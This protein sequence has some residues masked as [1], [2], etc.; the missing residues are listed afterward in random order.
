MN[1]NQQK[2]EPNKPALGKGLASLLPSAANN[3]A[4]KAKSLMADVAPPAPADST[5]APV[6]ADAAPSASAPVASAPA[7]AAAPA[8]APAAAPRAPEIANK[9]R[10]AGITM[11]DVES[12][13]ANEYQM[14][15]EFEASALNE[16][17][18]SIRANGVIQPL[19]T[20]RAEDG[21]LH[22]IAGERRLRAS[23]LAGLKQVPVVIKKATDKEALE[24]ALIENVQREDLNCVEVA[25]SYFQLAEDF[26]L[27]Q[28]EIAKRVGKDRVSVA[29]HLRLLK[30]P[31]SLLQDLRSN[32]LSYGHGRALLSVADPLKRL[33]IRNAIVEKQLSVRETERIIAELLVNTEKGQAKLKKKEDA[34][35]A[36]LKN[37]VERLGRA[38]G[39]RVKSKG[40]QYRGTIVIDYFSKEDLERISDQLLR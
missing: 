17:A 9:D 22:L 37:F 3:P 25:T 35:P 7:A 30:L 10:I 19:I 20:R 12:I 16:L 39:T 27:T 21:K 13:V 11:A 4:L 31:E 14:R 34:Q 24:L 40:D 32:K 18:D 1:P 28:E 26:K 23:K 6:K 33:E 36:E 8:P 38:L 2:K 5:A 15:R 29:N